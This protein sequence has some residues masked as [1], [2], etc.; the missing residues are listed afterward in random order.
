MSKRFLEEY[1][2]EKEPGRFYKTYAWKTAIGLQKVDGLEPSEYL[3]NTAE[4]HI[5]GVI[6]FDDAHEL[7]SSYYRE[8]RAKSERTEEAD[9]VSVRIAQIISEKSFVFSPIEFTTIHKRLFEGI[10]SHAGKIRDYNITKDEWVLNGDTVIYGNAINLRETLEY[11]FGQEKKFDYK[12][13]STEDVIKHIARFI[14]NLWQIHIFGEGNTRTT[15]V[16]LIKYLTKLGFNVTND[17]FAENSWYFRNALVRANY[18]NREI[19]ITET[20]HYVELF[21]RNLLLGEDNL[22]SNREMHITYRA[23]QEDVS[24]VADRETVILD[25]LRNHPSITLA[26]VAVIIGKS[27]RTVKIAVKCMQKK[28]ILRRVGGRRE[29]TWVIEQEEAGVAE[30]IVYA[31]TN[32]DFLNQVY[33]TNYKGFMRGRWPYKDDTWVWMVRM[34]EQIRQGWK[35]RIISQDEIWEEYVLD[36]EPTYSSE[37]ERKYRIAVRIVDAPNGRQYHILGRY[38]FDFKNSTAGRHILIKDSTE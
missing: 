18:N 2:R 17:I 36:D 21:L 23:P 6:S 34:D 22:L 31:R 29:G 1:S 13:L 11:D 9:K 26:E 7:I 8:N 25:I 32:A 35:N 14:S 20:T 30:K 4:Q 37:P 16:F 28:G 12:G 24:Q 27:L 10:Y 15:A 19:G 38:R 3:V 5:N 33:G